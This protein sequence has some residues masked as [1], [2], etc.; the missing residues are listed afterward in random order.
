MSFVRYKKSI[1]EK[2][3]L[4]LEKYQAEYDKDYDLK[5]I[6]DLVI[7]YDGFTDL[8]LDKLVENIVIE[9]LDFRYKVEKLVLP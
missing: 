4:Y 1:E 8:K 2:A 5:Y 7:R 9:Y 3:E 6:I